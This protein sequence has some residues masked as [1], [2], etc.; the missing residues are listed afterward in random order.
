[1][2]SPT[3]TPLLNPACHRAGIS[4]VPFGSISPYLRLNCGN[5]KKLLSKHTSYPSMT[6]Q[7]LIRI[8]Q[9]IAFG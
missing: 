9:P 1:M 6:M 8:D 7:V 3:M 2:I 5:P 4:Y